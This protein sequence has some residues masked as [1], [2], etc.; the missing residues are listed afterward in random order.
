[1]LVI[2]CRKT[3]PDIMKHNMLV[4][5]AYLYLITVVIF[6]IIFLFHV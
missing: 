1:V 5:H 2:Y 4:P 6:G 3:D